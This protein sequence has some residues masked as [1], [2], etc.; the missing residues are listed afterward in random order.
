LCGLPYIDAKTLN[1]LSHL[2][3]IPLKSFRCYRLKQ[4]RTQFWDS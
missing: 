3:H 4:S 1:F 2:L